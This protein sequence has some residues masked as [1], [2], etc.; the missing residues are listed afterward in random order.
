M[1][2]IDSKGVK[3][4]QAVDIDFDKDGSAALTVG[5]GFIEEKLEAI[6]LLDDI[7][8]IIPAKVIQSIS[9]RIILNISRGD[10]KDNLDRALEDSELRE[11]REG[12]I[13]DREAEK[14]KE[15]R[16]REHESLKIKMS[17]RTR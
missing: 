14:L 4:G 13:A 10:L 11:Y 5:G 7:D 16:I 2:I 8:I 6:G 3:I 15:S 17:S 1:D 12:R 9:K